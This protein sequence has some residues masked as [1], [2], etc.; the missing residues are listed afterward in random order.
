MDDAMKTFIVPDLVGPNGQSLKI[1][2][3]P[4]R[5]T[6]KMTAAEFSGDA[7]AMIQP[8]PP[9]G[10]L[11]ECAR[12]RQYRPQLLLGSGRGLITI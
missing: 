8:Q 4:V 6:V 7:T 3:F 2:V 10:I 1:Q 5:T 11:G 9:S 12:R